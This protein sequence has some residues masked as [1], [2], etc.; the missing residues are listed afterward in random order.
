VPKYRKINWNY[1]EL[2]EIIIKDQPNLR[3]R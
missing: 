1:I 3:H 2:A